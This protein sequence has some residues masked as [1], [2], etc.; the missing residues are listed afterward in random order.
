MI[1][2]ADA[3]IAAGFMFFVGFVAGAVITLGIFNDML[4]PRRGE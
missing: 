1:E 3:L 2:L 4:A